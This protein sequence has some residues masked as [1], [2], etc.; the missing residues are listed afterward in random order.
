M[1]I[2]SAKLSGIGLALAALAASTGAFAGRVDHWSVSVSAT[3]FQGTVTGARSSPD[4]FQEVG[5]E[6]WANA[7]QT[8]G[9]Y[10]WAHDAVNNSAGCVTSDP[11]LVATARTLNPT[12]WLNVK[13]DPTS[14]QCTQISMWNRSSVLP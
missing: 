14:Y 3:G 7:G 10:C 9:A 13:F 5:C 2:L 4:T 1:R 8:P 12:S 6:V 11:G